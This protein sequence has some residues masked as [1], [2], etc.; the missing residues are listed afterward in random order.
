MPPSRAAPQSRA[1]PPRAG[2]ISILGPPNKAG[3]PN[4][5]GPPGKRRPPGLQ[6]RGFTTATGR[7]M[8]SFLKMARPAGALCLLLGLWA[9]I[10]PPSVQA[11]SQADLDLNV[12]FNGQLSVSVDGFNSSTRTFL[13]G[14]N[15]LV[16]PSSATVQNNGNLVETWELSV[17]TVSGGGD[18]QALASTATPPD[19]DEYAFQALFISSATSLSNEPSN[20]SSGCPSSSTASDWNQYASVVSTSPATYTSNLFSDP[21]MVGGVTGNPDYS[22]GT[23]NGDM[24]PFVSQPGGF[25][26][27][28]LCARIYMPIGTAFV[29]TPQVIKL[30]V[31]A[32]PGN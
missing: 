32:A 29:G 11:A 22:A 25:G 23:Q 30:T 17:S 24:I 9:F 7:A 19:V 15:A 4:L 3:P 1:G 16:V 28:G 27:R 20:W 2:P 8:T 18:W 14:S 31:T 13:A 21:N 5:A 12:T 26:T 6:K 10:S